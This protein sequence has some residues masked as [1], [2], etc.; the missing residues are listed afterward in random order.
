MNDEEVIILTAFRRMDRRRKED[1][2]VRMVRIAKTH[3]EHPPARLYLVTGGAADVAP[4]VRIDS[5]I[6]NFGL[7]FNIG[8]TVKL[9]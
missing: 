7:V 3:P 1:A 2:L 8:S 6:H 9:K 5:R 4:P